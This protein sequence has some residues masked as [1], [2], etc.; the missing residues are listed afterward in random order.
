MPLL[1][2]GRYPSGGQGWNIVKIRQRVLFNLLGCI[3]FFSLPPIACT[4]CANKINPPPSQSV[5]GIVEKLTLDDLAARANLIILGD[6]GDVA[7]QKEANGSIYTLI[8]FSVEQILKGETTNKVVVKVPG[9]ELDGQIQV[10]EDAPTF[11][12][13]DR[14]VFFL[15]NGDGIFQVFG[16]FQGKFTID[17]NDM[18][19]NTP[20][21]D[22]IEQVK[23][24]VAKQ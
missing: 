20:L 6:V 3:I 19:G 15:E 22:F 5:G 13:G 21:S 23:N 24:A 1:F 17:K 14:V 10:V 16:G 4:S 18:V 11:Q 12:L 9:G 2:W 7:Y 8:T